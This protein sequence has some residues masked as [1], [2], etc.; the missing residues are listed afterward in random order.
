MNKN[1]LDEFRDKFRLE[2][3][4][5][6]LND[7]QDTAAYVVREIS[8]H[9]DNKVTRAKVEAMDVRCSKGGKLVVGRVVDIEVRTQVQACRS[10]VL[11]ATGVA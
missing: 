8:V 9:D 11:R 3:N 4:L 10:V 7:R 6:G 1:S 2:I 5:N